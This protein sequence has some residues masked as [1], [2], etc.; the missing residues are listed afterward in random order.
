MRI[1]DWSS[2]VCSSDL[3]SATPTNSP[4]S[5]PATSCPASSPPQITLA[6][7]GAPLP[8]AGEV[9]PKARVRAL[10]A[11][12]RTHLPRQAP[13]QPPPPTHHTQPAP[14]AKPPPPHSPPSPPPH[15]TADRQSHRLNCAHYSTPLHPPHHCQKQ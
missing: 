11:P 13:P 6:T 5:K 4:R 9:A 1:S 8:Q 10:S 3:S 15:A 2:D 7:V 12:L 14:N